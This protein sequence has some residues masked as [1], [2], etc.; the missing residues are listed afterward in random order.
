[1][2]GLNRIKFINSPIQE[3]KLNFFSEYFQYNLY[4]FG[5]IAGKE[6]ENPLSL[7]EKI[8]ISVGT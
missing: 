5:K 1:M 8:R 6:I 2:Y 3:K 4:S 7:V